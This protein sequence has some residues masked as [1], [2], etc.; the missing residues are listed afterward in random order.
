MAFRVLIVDDS[1]AMRSFIRKVLD[2]SGF[3]ASICVEAGD[4]IEALA[5]LEQDWID[6]ILTDINMPNMNGVAFLQRLKESGL[7]RSIPVV[8]IST[9]ATDHRVQEMLALG[10]KGYIPKPFAPEIL[11]DE[12][13]RVLKVTHG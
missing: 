3:D 7:T 10:A 1:P 4:G 9:D 8:V 13:E 12:L 2:L 11:R 6:V 5:V